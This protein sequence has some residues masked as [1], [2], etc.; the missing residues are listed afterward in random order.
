MPLAA[1]LEHHW[2]QPVRDELQRLFH[3]S[4]G[5]GGD[6]AINR[7]KDVLFELRVIHEATLTKSAVNTCVGAGD[8]VAATVQAWS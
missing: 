5:D 3:P 6:L 2:A 1:A 7:S 8:L 4:D